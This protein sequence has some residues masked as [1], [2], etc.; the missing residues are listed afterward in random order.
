MG[1]RRRWRPLKALSQ[2]PPNGTY[3]TH[4]YGDGTNF[5]AIEFDQDIAVT[6]GYV[7]GNYA[8]CNSEG[9]WEPGVDLYGVTE[10]FVLVTFADE[11]VCQP[12]A[13]WRLGPDWPGA[14]DFLGRTFAGPTTGSV[15]LYPEFLAAKLGKPV[16][17]PLEA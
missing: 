7:E 16:K 4:V 8:E 13:V 15:E 10:R 1:G 14:M 17:P 5:L 9:P 2:P 3:I 11:D 12:G 6:G